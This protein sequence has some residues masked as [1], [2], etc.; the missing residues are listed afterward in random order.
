MP[1]YSC[2]VGGGKLISS[3]YCHMFV[4]VTVIVILM[5]LQMMEEIFLQ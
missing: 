5:I 4:L 3:F 2:L 1:R